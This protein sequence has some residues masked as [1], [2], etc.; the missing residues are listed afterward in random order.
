MIALLTNASGGTAAATVA[1]GALVVVRHALEAAGPSLSPDKFLSLIILPNSRM[2]HQH[3]LMT[4]LLAHLA[5]IANDTVSQKSLV[6]RILMNKL[7][8]FGPTFPIIFF[9][10]AS[11]CKLASSQKSCERKTDIFARNFSAF[12]PQA[13]VP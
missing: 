1:V 4:H 9:S 2:K 13:Y 8:D 5:C 7:S 10:R 11:Q 3:D 12:E 6:M